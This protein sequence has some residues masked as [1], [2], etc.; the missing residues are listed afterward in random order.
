MVYEPLIEALRSHAAWGTYAQTLGRIHLSCDGISSLKEAIASG[1]DLGHKTC[2][3]KISA[4]PRSAFEKNLSQT[5]R[6]GCR[7]TYITREGS[8]LIPIYHK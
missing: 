3:V 7:G 8:S 5:Q 1:G 6:G 2:P 4:S